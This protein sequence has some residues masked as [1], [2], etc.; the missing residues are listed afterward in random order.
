MD[1]QRQGH[2]LGCGVRRLARLL[3]VGL[4]ALVGTPLTATDLVGDIVAAVHL[5]PPAAQ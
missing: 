1:G 2:D 3:I 5:L 4:G